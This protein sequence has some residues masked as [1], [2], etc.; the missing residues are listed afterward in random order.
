MPSKPDPHFRLISSNGDATIRGSAHLCALVT[1]LF[2][3][4]PGNH[5]SPHS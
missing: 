4:L 5:C 3:K 1:S 2:V